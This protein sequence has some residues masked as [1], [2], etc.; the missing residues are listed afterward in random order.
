MKN[1]YIHIH[2]YFILIIVLNSACTSTNKVPDVDHI[3]V[4]YEVVRFEE[5]LMNLDTTDINKALNILYTK[6]PAFSNIY[7]NNI[8][9]YVNNPKEIEKNVKVY[10]TDS[11]SHVI[12]NL[13]KEKYNIFDN[14]NKN[15]KT[16]FKYLKYYFPNENIP[17]IYTF[18]STFG[19]QG[20]I[21]DVDKK[22]NGLAIGLDMYLNEDI[23]YKS[24]FP[25]APQFSDYLT[26][27]FNKDHIVRKCM[28]LIVED[29]LGNTNG[30]AMI[31]HMIHNGKKLY[32]LDQLL[33]H[34]SDT[35]IMEYNAAQLEWCN[36]N[37]YEMWTFFRNESLIYETKSKK[38]NRF[39]QAAPRTQGM[40]ERAPGRTAN[41]IGWKIV[42]A[43]MNRYPNTTM[44]E[45]IQIQPAQQLLQLSKYKPK[46]K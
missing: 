27:A 11:V 23:S 37:E 6:Y 8:L 19:Y 25:K 33:P 22:R 12:Y 28:Q 20:F 41:Y 46:R 30:K 36:N 18:I 43:Y 4:D 5:D 40:D 15:F 9:P 31:D 24:Y 2:I 17:D 14:V 34:V 26:R 35:I 3:K 1:T 38:I 44:D 32:I 45:L 21:F 39:V 7:F 42:S 16:A 29:K 13:V 10:V